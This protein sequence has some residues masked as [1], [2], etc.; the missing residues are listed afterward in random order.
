MKKW[1]KRLLLGSVLVFITS[2]CLISFFISTTPGLY[3][4]IKLYSLK[5]PGTLR[6]QNLE[7]RLADKFTIGS[8]NYDNGDDHLHIRQ[9][10]I[11][12]SLKEL[13][14]S[15]NVIELLSAKTIAISDTRPIPHF[16]I[17][18]ELSALRLPNA[19][20][21]PKAHIDTLLIKNTHSLHVLKDIN[22]SAR[23]KNHSYHI[24][25]LS[26]NIG[27]EQIN[28]SLEGSKNKEHL[29]SGTITFHPLNTHQSLP[30]GTLQLGGTMNKLHWEANITEPG[31]LSITGTLNNLSEFNQVIKWGAVNYKTI[32]SPMGRIELKG[33][34]PNVSLTINTKAGTTN[35]TLWQLNGTVNG[36]IPWNWHF[37]LHANKP[38]NSSLPGL[39][40][41]ITATGSIHNKDSAQILLDIS[42]GVYQLNPESMIPKL[43]FKRGK[44]ELALTP[45]TLKG[46]GLFH[47]DETKKIHML[48]S[49][50]DIRLDKPITNTQT[51]SSSMSLDFNSLDFL[52]TLNTEIGSP[53]GSLHATLDIQGSIAKP[54]VSSEV[55]LKNGHFTVPKLGLFLNNINLDLQAKQTRWN[56][57][58]ALGINNKII[59]LK[60]DGMLHPT[61][62]GSIG[63][64][65]NDIP[66]A[67]TQEYK[68]YVS[69]KLSLALQQSKLH[70]TGTILVPYAVITPQKLTSSVTLPE[71]VVY[72]KEQIDETEIPGLDTSM[73]I[74]VEMGKEIEVSFKGLHALLAGS[75]QIRQKSNESIKGTGELSV[76]KGE[77]K[78]FG[79][80]LSVEQGQ[81]LFT[82]GRLDNPAIAIRAIKKINRTD[83][84]LSS[85]NQLIDFNTTTVQNLNLGKQ[86]TVGVEVSGKLRAPKIQLFSIPSILSQADILS[87]LV[88]GQP[89]SQANKAG[90]QLLLA[91][92]SSMNLGTSASNA[93]QL[94]EQLK[95]N[96]GL[97][98]N[99]L[100][101]SNYN[102]STRQFTDSTG[103][104]VGKKLSKR[105][106][107]S[108]NV[109]M[110]RTDPNVLTLKY[111]LNK[112]FSI[113]V[114]SSDTSNGIDLLFTHSK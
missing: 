73:D 36:S 14:R 60:G 55:Q 37:N 53:Q 24:D 17:L 88:L 59:T 29:I 81:L 33:T 41:A 76:I 71:D 44:L 7:G 89:A 57:N 63:I 16:N 108:Y 52:K 102:Q 42:P 39:Y 62:T 2:I 38:I 84:E 75:V 101:T 72:K 48:F 85:S 46:T 8:L 25:T 67:N 51:F 50:P 112:L 32:Y 77:Y 3:V 82:G 20:S 87:M 66:I 80:N 64:E 99:I 35:Q 22:L 69:P 19:L 26:L 23:I 28:A 95:Q 92:L 21:L 83:D 49:A 90:G 93:S 56:V 10:V 74:L 31:S 13:F 54:I 94:V 15:N 86:L 79:Q 113:Q 65:G 1:F 40:T 103:F 4:A 61:V 106:Y 11:H 43:P 6:I 111:L 34:L 27:K 91:A 47:L 104:V 5:L 105:I 18:Q 109:G 30:K 9:L 70:V 12:W 114:S 58:G 100:T 97:D 107:L 110:S 78:A 68:V 98:F 45:E 96:I